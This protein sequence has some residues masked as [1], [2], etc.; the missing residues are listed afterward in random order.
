MNFSPISSLL[1]NP[2]EF[3]SFKGFKAPQLNCCSIIRKIDEIR[4]NL[5]ES[6]FI[7]VYCFTESWLKPDNDSKLYEIKNYNMLRVDRTL[8]PASGNYT[9]GG[10]IICFVREDLHY[11]TLN[12][13]YQTCDL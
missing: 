9:H 5:V 8:V 10:G 7:E 12:Y 13:S 3:D 2:K 4:Y 11:D 6:S 1:K